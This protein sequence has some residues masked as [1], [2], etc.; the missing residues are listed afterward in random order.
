MDTHTGSDRRESERKDV[1]LPLKLKSKNMTITHADVLDISCYGIRVGVKMEMTFKTVEDKLSVDEVLE[2]KTLN[3]E[4]GAADDKFHIE[5]PAVVKWHTFRYGEGEKIYE[6]GLTLK[7][8]GEQKK[9][10]RE[11]YQEL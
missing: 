11:Y 3:L 1:F 6:L 8:K 5:A 4:I 10:W 9:I 7:L 2:N